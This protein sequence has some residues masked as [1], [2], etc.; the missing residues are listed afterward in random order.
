MSADNRS[1]FTDALH[2]LGNIIGPSEKRDAIHLAVEPAIAAHDLRAGEHVGFIAGGL[3]GD[4]VGR[5]ADPV[6]IVDPFL[7]V[8]VREGQMFWLVVYPRQITSLRHVWAHPKFPVNEDAD[9]AVATAL[10]LMPQTPDQSAAVSASSQW[11]HDFADQYDLSYSE[12][13]TAAENWVD[14]QKS[15]GWGEY[16]TGGSEMEGETVPDEFWEHYERVTGRSVEE[17][18]RGSFFS[19]SC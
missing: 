9:R 5:C 2:T 4:R 10:A 15:G 19:C 11:M 1:T 6:G 13:I 7:T 16:I 8:P 14:S 17:E 18:H 3:S 12:M